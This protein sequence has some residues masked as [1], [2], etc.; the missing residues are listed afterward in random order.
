MIL[1]LTFYNTPASLNQG[2]GAFR[3]NWTQPP[4]WATMHFVPTMATISSPCTLVGTEFPSKMV[5]LP[6]LHYCQSLVSSLKYGTHSLYPQVTLSVSPLEN[7]T[8]FT[9]DYSYCHYPRS[10]TPILHP[11]YPSSSYCSWRV[12]KA[13]ILGWFA[14]PFSRVGP[15]NWHFQIVVLEKTLQSCL[16]C[17]EIKPVNPKG[18]QPW[19]FIGR[20]DTDALI[21]WPP[22]AKEPTYWKRPWCWKRLRA[23]REEGNRGWNGWIVS[24]TPWT[25]VWANS[26]R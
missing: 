12:L 18:N 7:F 24:L 15:E 4:L 5:V 8:I 17:E 2:L 25:W 16:D 9:L 20:T 11:S 22:D 19:I 14:I 10:L 3:A 23:G 26:G 21:L 6:L 13:W 1:D